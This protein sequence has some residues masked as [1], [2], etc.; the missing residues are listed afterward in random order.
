MGVWLGFCLFFC[1]CFLFVFPF[2]AAPFIQ[3]C[4]HIFTIEPGSRVKYGYMFVCC[5]CVV[6]NVFVLLLGFLVWVGFLVCVLVVFVLFL[7]KT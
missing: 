7:N 4:S 3:K 1:C 5:C 2:Q 6:V